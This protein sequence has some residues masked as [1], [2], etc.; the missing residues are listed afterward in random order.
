MRD[1]EAAQDQYKHLADR[2]FAANMAQ[3]LE[4]RQKG[5]RFEVLNPAQ[6]PYKPSSPDRPM[7]NLSGLAAGVI[8]GFIA[9]LA[10]E[11]FDASVKTEQEVVGQIGAPVFGEVPWLP[12]AVDKRHRRLSTIFACAGSAMLAAVYSLLLFAAWR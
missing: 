11:I 5:E 8:V 12:T 3:D 10:L 2:N 6:V 4:I 9:A 1:Y 7:L